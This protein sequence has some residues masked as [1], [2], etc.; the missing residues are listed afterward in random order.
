M[1]KNI[2]PITDNSKAQSFKV[3]FILIL[4]LIIIAGNF[5]IYDYSLKKSLSGYACNTLSVIMDQQKHSFQSSI[6]ERLSILKSHARVFSD[7]L[8]Y[9]DENGRK[10]MLKSLQDTHADSGFLALVLADSEGSSLTS[11]DQ[12]VD[13]STQEYFLRA[14]A[15]ET[16]LSEP[17]KSPFDDQQRVVVF[18]TPIEIEGKIVAVLM[19]ITDIIELGHAFIGFLDENGYTYI[20]NQS[21]AMVTKTQ[22]NDASITE[23]SMNRLQDASFIQYDN[24]DDIW[25]KASKGE[26]GHSIYIL[27]GETRLLHYAPVGVNDWYIFTSVSDATISKETTNILKRTLLLASITIILVVGILISFLWQRKMNSKHLYKL[28]YY[29]QLTGIP[30]IFKFKIDAKTILTNN[31]VEKFFIIKFDI[32]NFKMI[33]EMY[34]IAA[35]DDVILKITSLLTQMGQNPNCV[36]ARV[37]ADEFLIIDSYV[38][39]YEIEEKR[40]FFEKQ[41]IKLQLKSKNHKIEFRYGRYFLEKGETNI[42][43]ILEKVNLAHRIAREKKSMFICDYDNT[44]KQTLVREAQIE[45]MMNEAI[46]KS[47]FVVYLQPKYYL[48]SG[49][50]AGAEA[51]VRWQ[52]YG[53]II[54]YPNQFIPLFEKN[55]FI[56]KFDM[57]MLEEVC[58]LIRQWMEEGKPLVTISINFSRLH[59][60][61]DDFV[62]TIEEIVNRYNIPRKYIEIELTESTLLGDDIL[63]EKILRKLHNAGFTLSMDDF[64][65]GYSSLGLLKNLP[66]DVIKVD[67]SFFYDNKYQTRAKI[68]IESVIQMAKKLGIHTV[69]EGIECR[70]DIELL[71]EVG[72][73]IVQG[74][75]FAKPMPYKDFVVNNAVYGSND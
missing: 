20:Y 12:V 10:I 11:G 9:L 23:D 32:Y 49:Q 4:L 22:L 38:H 34:G 6:S 42:D 69:A 52:R 65:T 66:V 37:N 26:S 58:K 68:V 61:D 44:I 19:G 14:L 59:L 60:S 21:G 73:D 27:E 13:V 39:P 24:L 31:L 75:Y 70:E 30:N 71:K 8:L 54:A 35:G 47:E 33:N 5:M 25:L 28:A 36:Y 41:F 67:K 51:L 2:K 18:S 3:I 55:G 63:L 15:G 62:L 16:C 57:Y 17:F 56:L 1:K 72:C 50:M 74:Y 48:G 40:K 29:D 53:E 64:G 46:E 45:N 7:S 43:S